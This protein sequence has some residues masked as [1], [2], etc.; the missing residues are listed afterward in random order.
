MQAEM[1]AKIC[2]T[3]Q[4]FKKRRTLDGNLPP[5]NIAELKPWDSVHVY[6]IGTY[7]MSIRQQQP[8]IAITRNNSSMT[9]MKMVDSATGSFKFF[10][11]T[12]VQP[13]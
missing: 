7:S 11:D 3:C 8:G 13:R 9:C 1:F 2:N 10:R 12:G 4:Q 6:L 5:K